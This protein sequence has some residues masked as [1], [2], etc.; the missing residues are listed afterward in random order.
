MT[1]VLT[2]REKIEFYDNEINKI[3]SYLKNLSQ[4]RATAKGEYDKML[5]IIAMQLRNGKSFMI[6]G[7]EIKDPPVTLAKYYAKAICWKQKIEM[8]KA[9]TMYWN[10]VE[11]L[12]STV[13]QM[14]GWQTI[15]RGER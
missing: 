2:A 1:D 9:D 7:K 8:E 6:E 11:I 12:K 10:A 3:K 4:K 5:G 15:F 14:S 13:S